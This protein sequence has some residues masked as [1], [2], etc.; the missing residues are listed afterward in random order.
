MRLGITQFFGG[1]KCKIQMGKQRTIGIIPKSGG[2]YQVPHSSH[3]G[4]AAV[5]VKQMTLSDLHH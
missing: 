2:V 1:G 5:S 4:A 3:V